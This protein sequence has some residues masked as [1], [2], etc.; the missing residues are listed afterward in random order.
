MRLKYYLRGIGSGI[1]LATTLLAISFFFG[2][3]YKDSSL[4]DED[5]IARATELGMTMPEDE[6]TNNQDESEEQDVVDGEAA[7]STE[8]DEDPSS[9]EV[10]GEKTVEEYVQEAEAA[11]QDEVDETITYVSFSV[12]SGQSSEVI[13]SN[14][15]KEGLIDDADAFN[16]YLNKLGVDDRIPSGTFYVKQGSSYDDIVALLVNKEIRTT[17]PPDIDNE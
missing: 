7:D 1:V 12:R 4:S 13:S 3:G 8:I 2:G 16:K 17:T 6:S 9:S 10:A 15:Y 14:L 11:T 5:I